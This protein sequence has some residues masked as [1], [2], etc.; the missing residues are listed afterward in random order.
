ML[1]HWLVRPYRMIERIGPVRAPAL[2]GGVAILLLAFNLVTAALV[3]AAVMWILFLYPNITIPY[4]S[5][6]QRRDAN[7]QRRR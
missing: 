7:R 3:V 4:A 1:G 6:R 5:W 2:L